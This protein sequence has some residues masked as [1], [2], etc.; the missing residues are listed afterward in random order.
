M[1]QDWCGLLNVYKNLL[2]IP[3]AYKGEGGLRLSKAYWKALFNQIYPPRSVIAEQEHSLLNFQRRG[4]GEHLTSTK[5]FGWEL[6]YFKC[7]IWDSDWAKTPAQKLLYAKDKVKQ[8]QMAATLKSGP[9][10]QV[11]DIYQNLKYDIFFYLFH[12]FQ[13]EIFIVLVCFDY[14]WYKTTNLQLAVWTNWTN[15][16]LDV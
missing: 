15:C 8:A 2:Y 14:F 7:S 5:E 12:R 13:I 11:V 6:N 1:L 9:R 3:R 10:L 16:T 4:S